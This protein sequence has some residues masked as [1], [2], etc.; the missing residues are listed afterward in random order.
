MINCVP[1]CHRHNSHAQRRNR[2]E[3]HHDD[4][5]LLYGCFGQQVIVSTHENNFED[6]HEN[7]VGRYD[8]GARGDQEGCR[9]RRKP[10]HKCLII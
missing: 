10:Q 3:G 9:Q 1:T 8:K 6:E 2:M 7:K 5:D 4:A